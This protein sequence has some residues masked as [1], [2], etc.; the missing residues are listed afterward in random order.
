MSRML[1]FFLIGYLIYFLVKKHSAGKIAA[2]HEE[3][4]IE[5]FRDPVCGVY[6][7][8]DDAVVGKHDGERIHFCSMTCLE[9]YRTRLEQTSTTK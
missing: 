8:A 7:A 2:K 9:T 3:A 5:T 4:G 1:I 6:V